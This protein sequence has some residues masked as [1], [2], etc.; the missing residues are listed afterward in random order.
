MS[1][2]YVDVELYCDEWV[3]VAE[4]SNSNTSAAVSQP[5]AFSCSYTLGTGRSAHNVS[6][7]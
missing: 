5:E 1:T 4:E 7:K 2:E 3:W 6:I